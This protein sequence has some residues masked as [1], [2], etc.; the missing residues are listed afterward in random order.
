[1]YFSVPICATHNVV[2]VLDC[3]HV[4]IIKNEKS[5]MGQVFFVCS[6]NNNGYI[7][8]ICISSIGT[9]KIAKQPERFLATAPFAV[10]FLVFSLCK[11]F[12]NGQNVSKIIWKKFS[13][14]I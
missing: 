7:S 8:K 2:S 3:V 14:L 6:G 4:F 9:I 10:F 11:I 5:S 13:R 1:M 12:T